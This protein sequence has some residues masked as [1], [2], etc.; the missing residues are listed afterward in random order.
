MPKKYKN[1]FCKKYTHNHGGGG[2]NM[3]CCTAKM[4]DKVPIPTA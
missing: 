4:V 3:S 1:K 2:C